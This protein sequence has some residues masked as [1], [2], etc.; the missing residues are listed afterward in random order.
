MLAINV[1]NHIFHV[2]LNN[3][4]GQGMQYYVIKIFS[5]ARKQDV[6][7][8]FPKCLKC[9]LFFHVFIVK[10]YIN[11][12]LLNKYGKYFAFHEKYTHT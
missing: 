7:Q 2:N 1:L 4:L 5:I 12:L 6:L 8:T 10:V 11:L 9:S 3:I